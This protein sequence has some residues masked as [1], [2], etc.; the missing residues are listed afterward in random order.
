MAITT[1]LRKNPKGQESGG[2]VM[3]G[4]ARGVLIATPGIIMMGVS[5]FVLA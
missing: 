4:F 3:A 2:D 5:Y 1:Q